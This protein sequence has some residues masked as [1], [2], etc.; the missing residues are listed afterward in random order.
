M[1]YVLLFCGTP[2]DQA[3]FDALSHEDLAERYARVGR[4]FEEHGG[5]ITASNYLQPRETATTVRLG[6]GDPLVID[7]PFL[8]GNELIGGYAE[9]DVADLDAALA[10]AKRWPGGGAVEIRPVVQHGG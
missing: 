3:A 7:G 8:E 6:S 2:E 10:M 4:W 9:I 1:K 5:V